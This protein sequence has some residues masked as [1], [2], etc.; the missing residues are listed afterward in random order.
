M[1]KVDHDARR[2]EVAI[3]AAH[4]IAEQGLESLTTR[5]LAKAMSCS[6]GVLSHYFANKDE[7]VIAALSWADTRIEQRFNNAIAN[8]TSVDGYSPI[9]MGALP[10]DAESD[11][12]WRVR[13][14]LAAYTLTHE[15]L[16]QTQTQM[17]KEREEKILNLVSSLQNAGLVRTDLTANIITRS[18]IDFITGAAYNLLQIPMEQREARISFILDYIN[19]LQA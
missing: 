15:T 9:I 18:V 10:L 17:R 2:Q 11:M 16:R 4:I 14:N 5:N 3:A 12:E 6:I 1:R 7:I 13:L 8:N 19:A